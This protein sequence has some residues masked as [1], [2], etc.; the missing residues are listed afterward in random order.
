MRRRAFA[1]LP[2]AAAAV[3]AVSAGDGRAD[4]PPGA[5][6]PRLVALLRDEYRPAYQFYLPPPGG[7]ADALRGRK[8]RLRGLPASLDGDCTLIETTAGAD[9]TLTALADRPLTAARA[10]PAVAGAAKVKAEV[11]V[12]RGTN[13]G[14]V[15]VRLA[16]VR[17]TVEFVLEYTA[18]DGTTGRR[19]VT[20]RAAADQVPAVDAAV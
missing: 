10:V 7:R 11:T 19:P 13:L 18:A 8:Q 3:I 6:P 20:V 12:D 14:L 4:P 1:W 16:D 5:D 17:S 2:T 9:V 15:R